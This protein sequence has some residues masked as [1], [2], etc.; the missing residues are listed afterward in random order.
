LIRKEAPHED[1]VLVKKNL[2]QFIQIQV[3]KLRHLA[4]DTTLSERHN[5]PA[6]VALIE[7]PTGYYEDG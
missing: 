5:R 1:T 4:I 6:T 7:N 2:R 3:L